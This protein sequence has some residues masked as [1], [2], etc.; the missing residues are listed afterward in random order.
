MFKWNFCLVLNLTCDTATLQ[1]SL[2]TVSQE[3]KRKKYQRQEQQQR[4]QQRPIKQ[5]S[6]VRIM[7]QPSEAMTAIRM[8][9][10]NQ[11][12]IPYTPESLPQREQKQQDASKSQPTSSTSANTN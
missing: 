3:L 9:S 12:T 6:K 1:P 11:S 7:N 5:A 4:N 10:P 2:D 8:A